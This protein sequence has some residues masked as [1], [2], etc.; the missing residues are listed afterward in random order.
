MIKKGL[1]TVALLSMCMLMG[2]AR[3]EINDDR[4]PGTLKTHFT[5]EFF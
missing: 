1:L 2:M 3:R 4:G 5:N